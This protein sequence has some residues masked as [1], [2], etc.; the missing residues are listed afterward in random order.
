[1]ARGEVDVG[2]YGGRERADVVQL[3]V[4]ERGAHAVMP[5]S[6]S[7][8]STVFVRLAAG[9]IVGFIS[10]A[11][12]RRSSTDMNPIPLSPVAEWPT[13]WAPSNERL[14]ASTE[15]MSGLAA[16]LRVTTPNPV[17]PMLY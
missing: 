5:K 2:L 11:M 9:L 17:R 10:L 1:D 3:R 7:P 14:T 12:P 15:P 6:T 16:P 4:G 8:A 13:G